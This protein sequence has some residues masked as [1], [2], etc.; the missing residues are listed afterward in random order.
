MQ[1]GEAQAGGLR[2]WVVVEA[3]IGARVGSRAT[4]SQSMGWRQTRLRRGPK[5][6]QDTRALLQ[7]Q[8]SLTFGLGVCYFGVLGARVAAESPK[9]GVFSCCTAAC[10]HGPAATATA[11]ATD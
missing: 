4:D 7:E 5:T 3:Q 10:A 8:R 6:N 11:T 2:E 9:V 1:S